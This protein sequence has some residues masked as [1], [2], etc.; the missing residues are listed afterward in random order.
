MRLA[1]VSPCVFPVLT[2]PVM[3]MPR[4]AQDALDQ[5]RTILGTFV[6]RPWLA[7]VI[8]MTLSGLSLVGYYDPSLLVDPPQIDQPVGQ[9]GGMSGRAERRRGREPAAST[10]ASSDVAPLMLFGSEVMLLVRGD[11]FFT[12]AAARGLR[13]AV[14]R[15]EALPQVSAVMWMDRAPPLNLFGLPEPALPDHR[16]SQRRFDAARQRALANPMIAGQLLSNDGHTLMF[17]LSLDHFFVRSDADCTTRLVDEV[18]QALHAEELDFE[19]G[20]TG[21]LPI[22]LVM[23]AASQD[24]DR[25]FQYIAYGVILLLAA[26]L[27][28]GVSAVL[29]TA[30]APICGVF[31]T[32]GCIR[33]LHFEDNPFNHVVVPV[34]LS[35]VGFT[36]GVHMMTQIRVHRSAGLAVRGAVA[37]ALDEVGTACFLTSLTTAIGFGSLSW[38][39]HQ[40]VREFGWCCVLGVGITFLAIMTA[41]PL[42]CLTPLGRRVHRGQGRGWIDRNLQHATRIVSVVLRRRRLFVAAALLTTLASVLVSSRLQPDERILNAIPERSHEARWLRHVDRAFGGLETAQVVVHWDSDVASHSAEVVRVSDRV[43]RVLRAEPLLGAPLG[44]ARLIDALPGD[45][46]PAEK[47]AMVELLPPPLRRLFFVPEQRRLSVVFRLQDL[48]IGRYGPVLERIERRLRQ[49]EAEHPRFSLELTGGAVWR[50]ENLYR[51]MVDLTRS[52]A[53]ASVVIF[54]VL[55]LIYRSLRLGLI[56]L[57]PNILPLTATGTGMYLVGQ[58]LELVS[59]IAFTVCLGIAVDDTIHFLTRYRFERRRCADPAIA[60]ERAF[61]GVGAA[62]IMTTLVVISGFTTVLWSDTR[63]HHIFAWMGGGTILAALVADMLFLPALL[64]VFDGSR[65]E[66]PQRA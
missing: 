64:S 41:I 4:I 28:R 27:F 24:N 40:V 57:V 52:L 19:V 21:E 60:I 53:T 20:V 62:L 47:A 10:A 33:F 6:R 51:I 9:A 45:A 66:P 55:T 2:G 30:L 25:K 43:E 59:V 35:L 5:Q 50:W 56:A 29:I 38:A 16:A 61:Q 8:F 58:P 14:Q 11:N 34:L 3:T 42:A 44:I 63:E 22:R 1:T 46:A 26:I 23:S 31:W 32:M 65:T 48:G 54:L 49:L 36:D 13:R 7:A 18:Q 12:P 37:R 17:S 15:L 39:H